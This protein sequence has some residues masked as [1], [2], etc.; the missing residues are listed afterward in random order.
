MRDV[1]VDESL[2]QLRGMNLAEYAIAKTVKL[3]LLT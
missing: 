3:S 2:K 1:S